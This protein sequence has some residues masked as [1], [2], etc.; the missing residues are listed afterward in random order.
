MDCFS[1]VLTQPLWLAAYTPFH[2][3]GMD[4]S[5]SEH[6]IEYGSDLFRLIFW[7]PGHIFV[8]FPG[9]LACWTVARLFSGLL[10][11][12]DLSLWK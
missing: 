3:V 7:T 10:M 5:E 12:L 9:L 8:S 11:L 4:I 2:G 6:S 1:L